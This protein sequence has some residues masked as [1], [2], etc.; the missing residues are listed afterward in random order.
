MKVMIEIQPEEIMKLCYEG[1]QHSQWPDE[2]LG[3]VKRHRKR[4]Q[5]GLKFARRSTAR[6]EREES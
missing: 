5:D 4:L 3:F 2:L 1:A 6:I